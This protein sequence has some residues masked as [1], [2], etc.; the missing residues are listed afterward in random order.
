MIEKRDLVFKTRYEMKM[1]RTP[2]MG[3][4]VGWVNMVSIYYR[5]PGYQSKKLLEVEFY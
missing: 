1:G 4:I 2:S 5:L 3:L